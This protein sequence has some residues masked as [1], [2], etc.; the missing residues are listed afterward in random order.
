VFEIASQFI[1]DSIGTY[2]KQNI[3]EWM[4][5]NRSSGENDENSPSI[6]V[7]C[8]AGVSRSASSVIHFL[9]SRCSFK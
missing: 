5:N 2:D 8:H 6:Y 7:H 4:D 3:V 9:M 1:E